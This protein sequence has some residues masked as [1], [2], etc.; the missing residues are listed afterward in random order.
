ME[1]VDEFGPSD[2]KFIQ[3]LKV[4]NWNKSKFLK[5]ESCPICT[6]LFKEDE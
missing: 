5:Y 1:T 2:P 3:N 4:E 6:D